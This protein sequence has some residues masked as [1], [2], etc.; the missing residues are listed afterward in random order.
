[1]K[2]FERRQFQFILLVLV[3]LCA[4]YTSANIK[5]PALIGNNMVLQQKEQIII[6]GWDDAGEK[7]NIQ[8]SWDNQNYESTTSQ[9]G[10]WQQVVN[11]PQA[12]G[13]Y[14]I[15]IADRN[16]DITLKNIMIGEVWLCSGQSN[17]E[18]QMKDLGVWEAWQTM[19]GNNPDKNTHPYLRLFT[20]Q[21]DTSETER[22]DC[23]GIW[24][25]ADSTAV[26]N[27]SATAYFFGKYLSETLHV[28]VGL[29]SA[30]WGG[31]PA[32][33]WIPIDRI[34]S[35]PDLEGFL[36]S[37]NKASL[38]SGYP[39]KTY[40]GMIKPVTNYKIKGVIWYQGESNVKD[41]RLYPL[42]ME[43]LITTWRT[44]WKNPEMPFYFVQ[45]APFTYENPVTGALLREAQQKCLNIPNTGMAV[46]LDLVDNVTDIH[47]KNKWD[48]GKRLS[49]L[50]LKN[51]YKQVDLICEGP[52][53]TDFSIQKNQLKLNFSN[54]SSGII[55][56]NQNP[57]GF[58]IAGN[59]HIFYNART[60]AEN[61]SIIVSSDYVKEPVAV[62]YA[63]DNTTTACLFNKNGLPAGL[64][65]TDT[66]DI[67]TSKAS[68]TPF[69]DLGHTKVT[70]QLSSLARESDIY[71]AM[72]QTP[73]KNSRLYTSPLEINES[74]TLC[75]RVARNGYFAQETQSWLIAKHEALNVLIKYENQYSWQFAA[76]GQQALVDGIL[77]SLNYNDGSW[78]GFEGEDLNVVIDL[79]MIKTIENIACNF[80][81][82][83]TSWIFLPQN[84]KFEVSVDGKR[85][86]EI[87][88][89]EFANNK[90]E[91]LIK[92]EAL[93][94]DV[95]N[96]IRFVK[97]IAKSQKQCPQWHI[98]NGGKAWL[99]IDEIIVK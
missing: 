12:G 14:E 40:N 17:M 56:K 32:E 23:K 70:Y 66:W 39:G 22:D 1:M 74:G 38:W 69:F 37:P 77:G 3:L 49:L 61:N 63:F 94:F 58:L 48:V 85:Y 84:V 31:T 26:D 88:F 87:G 29:I 68:L 52:T 91:T 83:N 9:N 96:K 27:F 53:L 45:I 59:D 92:K 62:R 54:A 20:V 81:Q 95:K 47:P 98:G 46:T 79:G 34:K 33:T 41:Y 42:L 11:T 28:P 80:L 86:R 78:Q 76:S 57:T 90:N 18:Y 72:N 8:T 16:F 44:N 64:F 97:I 24:Q 35:N 55:L 25:I 21:R 19:T 89:R 36:K 65:R 5:L 75:A 99:F 60:T 30:A 73:D 10:V 50:A 15:K 6:W 13:P 7:V 67:I 43:N 2:S 93:S 4:K 71:Y 51:T 82:D